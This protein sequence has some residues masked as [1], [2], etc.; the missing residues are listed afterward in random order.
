MIW[1]KILGFGLVGLGVALFIA[2]F[3]VW[4]SLGGWLAVTKGFVVFLLQIG[5]FVFMGIG[6]GILWNERIIGG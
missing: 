6:I 3:M 2:T 5:A 4:S 1:S